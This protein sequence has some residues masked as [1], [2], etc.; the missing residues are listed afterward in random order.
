MVNQVMLVAQE[1]DKLESEIYSSWPLVETGDN[2]HHEHLGRLMD[3][4]GAVTMT[5]DQAIKRH[6]IQRIDFIKLDVDGHEY[7]VLEGGKITLLTYRPPILMEFAPYLFD[8][9]SH[10]FENMMDLFRELG[11]TL[12]DPD[13]GKPLPMDT[14]HLREIIPVGGS[15]NVLLT[16]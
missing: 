11:Y 3:T 6:H 9:E 8:P 2:L 15:R 14:D 10:Q 7:S 16:K 13:T 4:D 12:S 5:L 1:N